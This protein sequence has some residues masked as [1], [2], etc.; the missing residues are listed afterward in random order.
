MAIRNNAADEKK[1]VQINDAKAS[2]DCST[3]E[4]QST[5]NICVLLLFPCENVKSIVQYNNRDIILT[6]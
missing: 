1:R 6:L 3:Y 5:W 2:V 4:V